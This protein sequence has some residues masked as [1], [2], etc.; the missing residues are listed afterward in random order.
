VADNSLQSLNCVFSKRQAF[1][2]VW[3]RFVQ[4][5]RTIQPHL[6]AH[7]KLFHLRRLDNN[8]LVVNVLQTVQV[9]FYLINR[10]L[11][12]TC[13]FREQLLVWKRSK[14]NIHPL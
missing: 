1:I 10:A 14:P 4:H 6:E 8:I 9:L 13:R 7:T 11:N 12:L 2:V 5:P 3:S